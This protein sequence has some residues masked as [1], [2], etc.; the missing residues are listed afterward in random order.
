[1]RHIF[2]LI[3]IFPLLI[4]SQKS[5]LPEDVKWVTQSEEYVELCKQIYSNAWEKIEQNIYNNDHQLNMKNIVIVMDLDETV[6][7]NSMYQIN[8]NEKSESFSYKSWNEFVNEEIS[9]LV[10]GSKSFIKKYKAIDNAKIV[11]ISNRDSSTLN[12]T[13]NNMK[14]LG[15]FYEDDIYMLRENKND[16]KIIRR[17]EVINGEGR[18]IEHGKCKVISYFGD[19]IGDFPSNNNYKF[20]INKFIFPNPMYGTW[21]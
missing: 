21:Q 8:L 18:M 7:D 5:K 10:P 15:V 19:A 6:L 3:L 11:Y 16:T 1:M 4:I 20:S 17:L 12:A 13:I 9:G 14:K 2:I